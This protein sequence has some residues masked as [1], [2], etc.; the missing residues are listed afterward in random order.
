MANLDFPEKMEKAKERIDSYE[1]ILGSGLNQ[2]YT[3]TNS[4]SRKLMAATHR[5]HA[6]GLLH[7]E[8]AI[9]ETGYEIRFGEFSS[10][11]NQVEVDSQVIA[12]IS[13]FSF[14]PDHHFWVIM[15]DLNSK[16]L[17]VKER[18]VYKH[19]TESYG[20]LMNT[21]AIDSLQIGQV[22]PGGTIIEKSLAFDEWNNRQDGVNLNTAYLALD[23]NMEDSV[24]ISK[25]AQSKLVA[26]LIKPVKIMINENDIPLNLYGDDNLYKIIPDIGEDISLDNGILIG[27]RKEKKEESLFMQ[28]AERL[29][30]PLM[31]DDKYTLHGK[32]IDIN[33]YCNNPE[34]LDGPYTKQLN[35]YY[36]ELLRE[37]REFISILTPYIA[38]GYKLS[39]DLQKKFAIAKRI[40]NKDKFIDKRL[41]SN[42]VLELFVLEE[43]P[44]NIG[45][46]VSNRYGGKGVVSAIIP[47]ELM[48]RD[49]RTGEIVEQILNSSTM[50]GRENPGQLFE[51]SVNKIGSDICSMISTGTFDVDESLKMILDFVE[52]VAPKQYES[53]KEWT[54]RLDSEDKIFFVQS[55]VNDGVIHVS[56]LPMTES[57][58]IDKL[59]ILYERFPMLNT[60][61]NVP[62]K[63]SNGNYRYVETRR[64]LT[65]GKQ[66]TFR[67][68][69]YAEE[70][71]SATS[72]SATNIRNEN[73]KS[74]AARDHRELYSNTPVR[75]GNMECDDL[76]HAG[77]EY[78]VT[79][80]MLHSLSPHGRRLVEAFYTG[81]PYEV[82]IK[83]DQDSSNRSVEIVNAYLKTMGLKLKF[84]KVK[85]HKHQAVK[86]NAISFTSDAK[87]QAISFNNE[88]DFDFI[89]D[90][91]EKSEKEKQKQK[92]AFHFN[93]FRFFGD[94]Q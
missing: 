22:V 4:G 41:F 84:Y 20:Y 43:L 35:M 92:R 47:D 82:D 55:I 85:K 94:P 52:I 72:L 64:P 65:V 1:E 93:P 61:Y 39:Y 31:S 58:N 6:L 71:F 80:L 62:I 63:D 75:M 51:V 90:F 56:T 34:N 83:L 69:Q 57:M 29:K 87:Q 67:L 9:N 44:I 45:D 16:T 74:K 7:G 88:K 38:Q 59:A 78:V 12:R 15:M 11:L 13:K 48:P 54:E 19:I 76:L 30:K 91:E 37:S 42:I 21:T 66:Y 33:I 32:V 46:K 68:K 40:V 27:L 17:F 73:I 14:A 18:K 2:P 3:N 50:Y 53:L 77:V 36:N 49:P 23:G 79:A 10:S 8:K 89:K 28:S 25:S 81:D 60:K 70:K 5:T 26:S 86:F 24:W